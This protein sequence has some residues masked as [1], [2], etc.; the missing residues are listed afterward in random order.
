[1][2]PIILALM[3]AQPD[4]LAPRVDEGDRWESATLLQLYGMS[5]DA[6]L[7]FWRRDVFGVIHPAASIDAGELLGFQPLDRGVEFF[8]F[9]D[10]AQCF[11]TLRVP[12]LFVECVDR[13]R[14][15]IEWP[16]CANMNVEGFLPN[17][18]KR[19]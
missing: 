6:R 14:F 2:L 18:E 16:R 17:P 8:W 5:A 15:N 13:R 19:D 10:C 7:I 12:V 4:P 3:L 9:D 1:M 11:R